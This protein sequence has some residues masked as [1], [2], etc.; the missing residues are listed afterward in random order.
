MI[1]LHL[2]THH[3]DGTWSPEDLVKYAL[4]IGMKH[5]AV[6]DHDTTAG[7]AQAIEAAAGRLEIIPAVEINTIYTTDSQ[8]GENAADSH[9]VHI[10]GYFVDIENEDLQ[11]VL[12]RQRAARAKHVLECIDLVIA[13][14]VPITLSD[15]EACAGKGALGKA[16]ITE[17]IVR[18]GGAPD[19]TAAY[20]KYMVRGSRYYAQR[21]SVTP[22]EAVRAITAAGGIASIAHPGREPHV[23]PLIE[24]L[25]EDG[26]RGI[27]AYHRVHGLDLLRKY[28]R[29]AAKNKMLVTGGSDCH[30]PY[31]E[32]QSMMG[33]ISLPPEILTELCKARS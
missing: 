20:H 8:A 28:L 25:K 2:H 19:L 23:L 29:Y 24:V 18:A 9:D 3:S 4:K 21:R 33:Q 15:V 10:L 16:H 7:V 26:L 5:I 6:T 17:A 32:F 13:S 14:G 30:G 31:E 22:Q 11:D 1:D 12:S 27:E